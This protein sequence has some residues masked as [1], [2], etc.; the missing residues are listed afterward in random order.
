MKNT[1]TVLTS[2][3][4]MQISIRFWSQLNPRDSREQIIA[5]KRLRLHLLLTLLQPKSVQSPLAVCQGP[6][7]HATA[8]P[9]PAHSSWWLSNCGQTSQVPRC[10]GAPVPRCPRTPPVP[11]CKDLAVSPVSKSTHVQTRMSPLSPLAKRS[12]SMSHLGEGSK[13]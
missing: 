4:Q 5:A 3:N 8:P 12:G 11:S 10:P 9:T 6:H 2:G 13:P 7:R 1:P